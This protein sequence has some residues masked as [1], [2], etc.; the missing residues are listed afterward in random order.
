MAPQLLTYLNLLPL[1]L[2]LLSLPT[3]VQGKRLPLAVELASAQIEWLAS[4]GGYFH[5]SV[6]IDP[7]FEPRENDDDVQSV[8]N[9]VPLGLFA[10]DSFAKGDAIMKIPRHC[11][12]TAGP[13]S[14]GM[15]QTATN[16]IK[17]RRL[18]EASK[19]APY[20]EYLYSKNTVPLP[21]VWSDTA[22][23][24]IR[25][26]R[27]KSFSPQDLTEV[28]FVKHCYDYNNGDEDDDDDGRSLDMDVIQSSSPEE[29]E[30]AYLT[31]V[32]RAWTDKLVPVFDMLNH[33]SGHHANVDSSTP[34]HDSRTEV[35]T[36]QAIRDIQAGEQL[37]LSYMD[38]IDE[39]GFENEYVL[40]Q[41]LRDFGFVDSYPQRWTFPVTS[42]SSAT[43][44][45][46]MDDSH[47]DEEEEEEYNIV[48]DLDF[49]N[50]EADTLWQTGIRTS[51]PE[52]VVHWRTEEPT[53][54]QRQQLRKELRRLAKMKAHVIQVSQQIQN[55]YERQVT[56][57]YYNSLTLALQYATRRKIETSIGTCYSSGRVSGGGADC[58]VGGKDELSTERKVE[59]ENATTQI[60]S[61]GATNPDYWFACEEYHKVEHE[62]DLVADFYSHYQG[63]DV[64]YNATMDDA[65]LYLDGYLHTCASN[66]PHYHEFLVHYPARFL[67]TVQRVIF[68]GGG[69]S[70][71]LHE[72]LKYNASLELVVGLEL[73]QSV[74]RSSFKNF[75]T[76]PHWDNDKVQWYFGD[77]AKR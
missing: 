2:L 17:E 76:Q 39:E 12:L 13:D 72:V 18:K 8:N 68:I 28:S 31:V 52:M 36:V 55:E 53:L 16:L 23:T 70:M 46:A 66:R 40:P 4:H 77:A 24:L 35:L 11:L 54:Q 22:Q 27:G 64:Y 7:L 45:A 14:N 15:C 20:V 9:H 56:L 32:S 74:V 3:T 26:I 69:D 75:G 1:L 34:V 48:F 63:V 38:C 42:S 58:V 59:K 30:F 49:V 25:E 47:D 10:K 51:I 50:A 62:D 43:A 73:D 41:M 57:E 19:Y 21:S 29:L 61:Q 5:P 33:H 65:C 44:T 67:E 71:V 6:S 60:I 37:F